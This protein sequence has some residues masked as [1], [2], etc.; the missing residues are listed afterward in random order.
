M[1][2]AHVIAFALG[3]LTVPILAAA[4]VVPIQPISDLESQCDRRLMYV[5][6]ATEMRLVVAVT[7]F[8]GHVLKYEPVPHDSQFANLVRV[9]SIG[10]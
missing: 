4:I 7:G 6:T 3:F 8:D 1:N 10:P 9:I 5:R 2:Y